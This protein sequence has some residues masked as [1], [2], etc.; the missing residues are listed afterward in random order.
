MILAQ[1]SHFVGI[2]KRNLDK[3]FE[4]L[5]LLSIV[6]N[7][8]YPC[9]FPGILPEINN[10]ISDVDNKSSPNSTIDKKDVTCGEVFSTKKKDSDDTGLS[11]SFYTFIF[12]QNLFL[13]KL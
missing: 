4:I 5:F 7:C 2:F 9:S 11:E 3:L 10:R 8:H 1:V 12:L 13:K 6:L